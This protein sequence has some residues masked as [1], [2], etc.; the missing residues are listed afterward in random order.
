MCNI[1]VIFPWRCSAGSFIKS[2][3]S[4]AE[5]METSWEGRGEHLRDGEQEGMGHQS[6]LAR[7]KREAAHGLTGESLNLQQ[8]L[9]PRMLTH[10]LPFPAHQGFPSML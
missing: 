6:V 9:T 2:L 10:L 1:G 4:F 8:H 3:Q 7:S 5:R